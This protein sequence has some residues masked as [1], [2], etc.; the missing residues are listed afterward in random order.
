[1]AQADASTYDLDSVRVLPSGGESLGASIVE[2]AEA[3]FDG[4]AVHEGY[5]QTEA[6]MLV[7]DCTSLADFREGTIGL[8][9]PGHEI[10]I[11]PSRKSA[12][13][14]QSP[15]SMFTSVCP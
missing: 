14:V 3:V 6:N 8:P 7:G 2:W 12:S 15:A 13:E 4:A 11:V 5:G 10:T 1:M 9:G